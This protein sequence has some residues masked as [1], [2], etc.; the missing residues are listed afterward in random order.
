M[1]DAKISFRIDAEKKNLWVHEAKEFGLTLT[2]Y[3]IWLI[4]FENQ[5]Y[6]I[7]ETQTIVGK[8]DAEV[9]AILKDSESK[10]RAEFE[11]EISNAYK[12]GYQLYI[13]VKNCHRLVRN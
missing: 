13:L 6:P 12:K 11:K 9:S 8:S 5:H 10:L 4:D 3:L 1:A 2:N 7:G